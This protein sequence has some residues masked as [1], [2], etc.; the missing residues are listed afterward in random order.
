MILCILLNHQNF[1]LDKPVLMKMNRSFRFH[2]FF[3]NLSMIVDFNFSN[4][5]GVSFG[6]MS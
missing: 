1:Y 2:L 5:D 4:F 6:L 3:E